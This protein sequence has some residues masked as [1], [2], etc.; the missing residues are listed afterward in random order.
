[1]SAMKTG[2][3]VAIVTSSSSHT[4]SERRI[5]L[6]PSCI[7][8]TYQANHAEPDQT[9]HAEWA[10]VPCSNRTPATASNPNRTARAMGRAR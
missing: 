9:Y 2:S 8:H 10:D 5:E 1:M 7:D 3:F 6:G 4:S